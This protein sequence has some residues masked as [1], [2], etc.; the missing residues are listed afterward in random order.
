M[1]S[2]F[3]NTNMVFKNKPSKEHIINEINY[4]GDAAHLL[5]NT[6]TTIPFMIK[7][8]LPITFCD[9]IVKCAEDKAS[10][11]VRDKKFINS[12][13]WT[14]QRHKNYPTLDF[15]VTDINEISYLISNYVIQNIFPIYEE[16]YAINKHLLEITDLFIVKYEFNNQNKLSNHRDGSLL[17]FSI[18]LNNKEDFDGGGTMMYLNG[19]E[20]KGTL[21]EHN[22]GELLI[23]PGK[24]LHA[25]NEITR[26]VRYLLVGF[27]NVHRIGQH[28]HNKLNNTL[29]N[30]LNRNFIIDKSNYL[31]LNSFS[32]ST[33][34]QKE[35]DNFIN[36]LLINSQNVKN[37]SLLDFNKE[38]YGIDEQLVFELYKF[39]MKRL[40]LEDKINDHYVEFWTNI[41][42]LDGNAI[43]KPIHIDKDEKTFHLHR[44]LIVPILSTITYLDNTFTPTI[45]TNTR[46]KK[47]INLYNGISLSFPTKFKHVCFNGE[48]LHGVFN[49]E[50]SEI[51]IVNQTRPDKDVRMTLCFNIFDKKPNTKLN[52]S[53]YT[54]LFPKSAD[55][56]TI[57]NNYDKTEETKISNIKMYSLLSKILNNQIEHTVID[58]LKTLLNGVKP[59]TITFTI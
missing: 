38:E 37:P 17:S 31:N 44:E 7:N 32:I 23:H 33:N 41:T 47:D 6:K 28:N 4:Y 18:L 42:F 56:F 15:A 19:V 46:F 58:E 26:G 20:N 8:F 34:Y 25:G 43:I 22:K 10:E 39:H 35:F 40:N 13:G 14:S 12:N 21:Y 1:L 53:K 3:S 24:I 16:K 52:S 2:I 54:K 48:T 5:V 59:S 49:L 45:L 36:R 55:Y 57:H 50:S 51:D 30:T 29:N 27:I 11:N 9:Y